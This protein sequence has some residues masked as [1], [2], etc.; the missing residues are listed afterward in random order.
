MVPSF[1]CKRSDIYVDAGDDTLGNAGDTSWEYCES[2]DAHARDTSPVHLIE[3]DRQGCRNPKSFRTSE[4]FVV[5]M[6]PVK[7]ASTSERF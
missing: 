2:L 1:R 4:L 7:S 6:E 5:V 3:N